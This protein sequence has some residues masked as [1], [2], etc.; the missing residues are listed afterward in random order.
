VGQELAA[1][2]DQIISLRQDIPSRLD[3]ESDGLELPTDKTGESSQEMDSA[4]KFGLSTLKI[5]C[6]IK[7]CTKDTFYPFSKI[8]K[9]SDLNSNHPD[10]HVISV[11]ME[12]PRIANQAS[13]GS[14]RTKLPS[15]PR[16][17]LDGSPDSGLVNATKMQLVPARVRIRSVLLLD[18]LQHICKNPEALGHRSQTRNQEPVE[19]HVSFVFLH[20]FKFFVTYETDIRDFAK[21][22][23]QQLEDGTNINQLQPHVSGSAPGNNEEPTVSESQGEF[24]DSTAQFRSEEAHNELQLL[25]RL[26][27]EHLA[28]VFQLRRGLRSGTQTKISFENLWLL[29]ELGDILYKKHQDKKSPPT[30]AKV[31]SITGGRTILNSDPWNPQDPLLKQ[32]KESTFAKESNGREGLFCLRYFQIDSDGATIF[33]R[34]W[35]MTIP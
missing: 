27:D 15:E 17:D 12:S 25:M 5:N 10:L 6:G 14:S 3:K 16:G 30:L 1:L 35:L 29:F 23:K 13:R 11:L 8:L 33:P 20:P 2:R 21:E 7:V 28:P 32:K 9:A 18:L 4:P 19:N 31:T 34:E 26:F 24:Y 22:L